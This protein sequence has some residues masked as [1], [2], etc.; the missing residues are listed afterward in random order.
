MPS[1]SASRRAAE[2]VAAEAVEPAHP[3]GGVLAHPVLVDELLQPARAP[4]RRR[5][6]AP[7]PPPA[8]RCPSSSS[9]STADQRAAA[10]G[11]STTSVERITR[12]RQEDDQV[13]L[14]EAGARVGGRA[15]AR[16]PPRAR[17]RR[18]SPTSRARRRQRQRGSGSRARSQL[19][20]P[21]AGRRGERPRAKR[22]AIDRRPNEQRSTPISARA[23]ERPES[24]ST[25]PGS[26]SPTSTNSSPFSS[27][28]TISQ[29]A[30][31]LQPRLRVR[32]LGRVPAHV[33]ARPSPRRA[34]PRRRV[35][36]AGR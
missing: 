21:P 7:S 28:K 20:R 34:R 4:P 31:A 35:A 15:E 1:P 6:S 2:P 23:V 33:D 17:P 12:E 27:R 24:R 13:A 25:I 11:P 19:L 3:L 14:R 16:A 5:G 29:T 36:C 18:A 9:P 26:C 8:P 22:A 30:L 32:Q 10:S